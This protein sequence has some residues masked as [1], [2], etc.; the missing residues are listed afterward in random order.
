MNEDDPTD[1]VHDAFATAMLGDTPLGRPVLGTVDSINA[2]TAKSIGGYYHR[3]YRPQN[4]VIAAAGNLDHDTVVRGVTEAFAGLLDDADAR[5]AS[6]RGGNRRLHSPGRVHLVSRQDE[7]ANLVLGV[8]GVARGDDRRYAVSALISALGGGSSSR[9]FQEIR[10]KRGLAYSVYSYSAQYAD[11]GMLGVYVGC[12]PAKVPQVLEICRSELAKV[13]QDG[14]TEDELAR[15][16][17]QLRGSTV[18]GLE[19]TGSRM[20]RI[21]KNELVDNELLSV[22]EVLA[23]FGGVSLDD[24]RAVAAELLAPRPTLA[25][26]GPFDDPDGFASAVA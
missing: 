21:G 8:P 1:A 20:S 18:L 26:L 4:M 12:L 13:A 19:D 6:P 17:G 11:L 22:D 9:L 23:R 25:V 7:Q 5:P 15:A 2:L 24:V 16:I 10:E 3:R 14:I